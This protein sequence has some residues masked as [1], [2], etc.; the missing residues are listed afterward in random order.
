MKMMGV[1]YDMVG[2]PKKTS[3]IGIRKA[4][5]N[6]EALIM[7]LGYDLLAQPDKPGCRF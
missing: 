1:H 3:N 4:K 2:Q 7:K 6:N 5:E